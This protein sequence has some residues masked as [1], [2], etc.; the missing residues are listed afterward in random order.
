MPPPKKTPTEPA[1]WELVKRKHRASS[2]G[3]EKGRWSA[4]KSVLAQLEYRRRG[5]GWKK[6]TKG[7]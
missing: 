4:R 5:G 6:A 7:E 2:E 1:L 3:G